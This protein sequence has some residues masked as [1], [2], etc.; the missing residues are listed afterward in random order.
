MATPNRTTI[1]V[2]NQILTAS[3]LNAE[4]NNLFASL[5]IVNAD[6]SAG[7]AISPSKIAG[8]AATLTGVEDLTNK[9]LT[10]PLII[11]PV[12]TTEYDNGSQGGTYNIDWSK[13][14]RQKVNITS[15]ITFTFS[16]AAEGQTLTL[17]ML[18]GGVG[19][20]T[21]AFPSMKWAPNGIVPTWVT[22]AGIT[23]AAIIRYDGS[24][25]YAQGTP[26]FK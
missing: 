5:S 14:D 6:I 8:T 19:G 3:A 24:I 23:N 25:Y 7:A 26:E 22:T 2:D 9:T 21:I 20:F 4:F 13:G 17:W 1:W 11:T 15:A 12:V 16:G 18:E 10:N